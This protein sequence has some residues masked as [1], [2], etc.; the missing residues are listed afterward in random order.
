MNNVDSTGYCALYYAMK[1]KN[2]PQIFELLVEFGVD[3]TLPQKHGKSILRLGIINKHFELMRQITFEHNL[4]WKKELDGTHDSIIEEI[5][6][7]E[8]IKSVKKC[9]ILNSVP[10]R[11]H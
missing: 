8:T 6:F 7:P 3:V 1:C 9:K 2:A 11:D 4:D 5:L 10:P